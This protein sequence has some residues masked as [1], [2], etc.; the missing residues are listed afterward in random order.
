M[1][2]KLPLFFSFILLFAMHNATAQL[3]GAMLKAAYNKFATVKNFKGH[4]N[5]DFDIPTISIEKMSGTVYYKWPDKFRV[6]LT[7]VAFLPR[8]NPFFLFNLLK[9][10]TAYVAVTNGKETIGNINCNV[11]TVLPQQDQDLVVAKLWLDPG[12][13]CVIRSQTTTK[14]SGTALADYTYAAYQRYALPD[15]I[16]FTVD[17]N[18]FKLPK[19][20]SADLNTKKKAS[21]D[22]KRTTGTITFLFSNYEVNKGFPESVFTEKE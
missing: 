10:S 14:S 21:S 22:I 1:I 16:V 9:D 3:P 19:M 12:S 11:V 8:Q 18:K 7:G 4:L 17:L 2:R 20:V 5:V 13:N 6:K 15:K